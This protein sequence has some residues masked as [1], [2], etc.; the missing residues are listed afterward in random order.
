M[1]IKFDVNVCYLLI[2]YL[3][4]LLFQII[5]DFIVYRLKCGFYD[6]KIKKLK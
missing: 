2:I 6:S 1:F 5:I 3:K 4:N